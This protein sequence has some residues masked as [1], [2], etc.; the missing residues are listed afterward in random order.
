M[1]AITDSNLLTDS[2]DGAPGRSVY[3]D[4][5]ALDRDSES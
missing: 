2:R 3:L 5:V 1:S 4:V